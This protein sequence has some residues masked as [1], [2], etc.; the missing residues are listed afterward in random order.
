MG[1]RVPS[2][3]QDEAGRAGQAEVTGQESPGTGAPAHLSKS[4]GPA[5][6][7]PTWRAR[8]R[9]RLYRHFLEPLKSSRNPPWFDA[10]GIAVGLFIGFG[11]PVG[12]QFLGMGLLRLALR[13]NVVLAFVSSWVS[14]PFLMIP[15]Y[16]GYYLLGSALLGRA[17]LLTEQAFQELMTPIMNMEYF[18]ESFQAFISLSWD[19]MGR[20]FAAASLIALIATPVSYFV[21]YRAFKLRCRRRA[22][23]IGI[24]YEMLIKDLEEKIRLGHDTSQYDG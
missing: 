21:S 23:R 10:R 13:F 22:M 4:T 6:P 2:L 5:D 15:M 20:W 14:N 24:S 17:P 12:A 3:S 16:Y 18:W 11:V 7:L 1:E 9:R 19:F 8:W